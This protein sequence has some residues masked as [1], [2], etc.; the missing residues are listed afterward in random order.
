MLKIFH[1]DL[2]LLHNNENNFIYD[3]IYWSRKAVKLY[4]IACKFARSHIFRVLLKIRMIKK[5][6]VIMKRE[7][8]DVEFIRHT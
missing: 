2:N 5:N 3:F 6:D 7:R 8:F 4:F 1:F